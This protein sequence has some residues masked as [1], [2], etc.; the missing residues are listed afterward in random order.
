MLRAEV[1]DDLAVLR[2]WETEWDALAVAAGRPFSAPA[3]MLAWWRRAAPGGAELRVVVA[4]DG[5]ALVG[6]APFYVERA[7]GG[8]ARYRVVASLRSYR[9]AINL[10][11]CVRKSKFRRS[12]CLALTA[13]PSI[14]RRYAGGRYS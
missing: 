9:A 12:G 14:C 7:Y 8:L 2:R 5:D 11:S 10:R 6:V 13:R 4:T 1:I 3:W